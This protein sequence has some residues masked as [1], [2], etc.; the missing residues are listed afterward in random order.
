MEGER[1]GKK[2]RWWCRDDGEGKG[3]G[4]EGRMFMLISFCNFNIV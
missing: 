3:K 4:R 2:W 1:K